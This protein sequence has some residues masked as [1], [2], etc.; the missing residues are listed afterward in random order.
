MISLDESDTAFL[1]AVISSA[2][3]SLSDDVEIL[4]E[5]E[6][7]L[8]DETMTSIMQSLII[9]RSFIFINISLMHSVI[10][11]LCANINY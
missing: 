1:T 6:G 8:Q 4:F 10:L 9:Y 5:F 2:I 3:S 11:G 7:P